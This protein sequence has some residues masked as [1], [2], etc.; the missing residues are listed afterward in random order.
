MLFRSPLYHQPQFPSETQP[1]PLDR[2]FA[3]GLDHSPA[4]YH[5]TSRAVVAVSGHEVGTSDFHSAVDMLNTR[6]KLGL[7]DIDCRA[8]SFMLTCLSKSCR[9][10]GEFHI[11]PTHGENSAAH[12]CH[13]VVLAQEIFR[14]AGLLA[15]D[16]LTPEVD[17]LRRSIAIGCLIH[18]MGE[19]LGELD[20]KSTRLNSSH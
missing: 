19:I 7:C 6:L 13:A 10:G 16:R 11:D 2:S 20:R 18:D 4:F 8:F 3:E 5:R 9:F 15:P 1:N 17:A 14:R 12:S